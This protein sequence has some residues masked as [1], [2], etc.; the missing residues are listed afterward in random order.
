MIP[1]HEVDDQGHCSCGEYPCGPKNGSAGKHPRIGNWQKEGTVDLTVVDSW[2]VKW[3][4]ANVG[5][6][7]GYGWF[8][9][10]VDP[11]K[12]G[13]EALAAL[14]A[15]YG[16]LPHTVQAQTGSGGYH[17]LFLLPLDMV[18]TNSKGSLPPGLD[19]RGLGGQIV[20]APS[21]SA[22]GPYRWVVAPSE[23]ILQPPEWLITMLRSSTAHV[24]MQVDTAPVVFPP[25]SPEVI[26]QAREALIKHGPAIDGDNGGL[27][28]VQ[29]G[30]IVK[31][32]F[33]LTDDEAWPLIVEWNDTCQPP[34]EL[35]GGTEAT[36]DLRIMLG[37]GDKY[38]KNAYGCRRE[39]DTLEQMRRLIRERKPGEAGM[40]ELLEQARKLIFTDPAKQHLAERELAL[41]TGLNRTACAL[42]PTRTPLQG[43]A[44]PG[45]VLVTV[46]LAEMADQALQTIREEVYQRSGVLCQV[47]TGQRT[48]IHDLDAPGIQDLMSK[49]SE[50]VRQDKE[51]LVTVIP[52]ERVATILQ[53]RRTHPEEINVIEAVTTVPIFL[54][55]GSILEAK[56]YNKRAKVYL[57]PSVTVSVPAQPTIDDARRA[58]AVLEDVVCDFKFHSDADR[59][60]W[61]AAVLSPLVK[62]A[63][64]NA[65]APLFCISA[66]SWGAGKT[67][68]ADLIARVCTGAP[69]ENK[70]YSPN[71]PAEWAKKLTAF[72]KA[73]SPVAILDNANGPV[74]DEKLA[75]LITSVTW[76]DRI[77]GVT[78]APPLPNVS[79]WIVTGNNIE[80]MLDIVRR[81]LMVRIEVE[82][83][84]PQERTGFKRPLLGDWVS[85]NRA[86]LLSAA[87]TILKAYHLADRPDQDLAPWGSFTGWSALVRGA[88]VWAGCADPYLTQARVADFSNDTENDAHDFW[89]SVIE[90]SDGTAHTISDLANARDVRTALG[91]REAMT[92]LYVKKFLNR[93]ID[94]PRSSKRIR[95]A[96]RGDQM[97]YRVEVIL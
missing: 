40:F 76:S 17:Y 88:L 14:V 9:L 61:L 19:I 25:A 70:P 47:V 57:N 5:L 32:D 93:F 89:I 3:P 24:P 83:E 72:V 65:P 79:T 18:L 56:G 16:E 34:W 91:T 55:D 86:P 7:T 92:P 26:Q 33:A 23:P 20:A 74:G 10:D 49:K 75:A 29:A 11:D 77:L 96:K 69:A 73:A 30:A 68:L 4:T 87:L 42:P 38:G 80:P 13:T 62:A 43:H 59:S 53:S 37:R 54:D 15:K 1:L 28:T 36:P 50:Y 22:K 84:R 44:V 48:Y 51:G 95:K 41:S 66:S 31:H 63:T 78:E 21:V 64:G 6:L 39:P 46:K 60:S 35:D 94:K 27:H 85:A 82:T 8:V 52:P 45:Q 81:C 90:A 2:I 67:L 12:G 97:V 71:D 58:V